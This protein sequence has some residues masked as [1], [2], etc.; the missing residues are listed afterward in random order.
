MLSENG[1]DDIVILDGATA[2]GIDGLTLTIEMTESQRVLSVLASNTPGGDG[3]GIRINFL[4]GGV[5]DIGT[6]QNLAQ[7]NLSL[8]EIAVT[9]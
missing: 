9:F 7:T 6:L 3:S 8:T 1:V 2:T 4:K 5:Q